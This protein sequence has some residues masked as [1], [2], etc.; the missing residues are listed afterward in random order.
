M[1]LPYFPLHVVAF[2]HLPLPLHIFEERYR[3][4]ARDLVAPES[5]YRGR[6]VVSM[7]TEGQ[8]TGEAATT[9]HRVGTICEVHTA[10]QLPDGRWVVLA[11]GG[12]RAELHEVDRSGPYAT[13]EV[14]PIPERAGAGA[15]EL[16]PEVQAALD[17]Y[18]ET[19]KR[20]AV[21][22]ASEGNQTPG[23]TDVAASLDEV[24]KPIHLPPDPSSASYAVGGVLQIELTRKQQLLELPDA[25]SRLRA[26]LDLLRRESR[27]LANS[28]M[29]PLATTDLEYNPN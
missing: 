25:V 11:V 26:E 22:A 16:L 12:E 3:A 6:F 29:P 10:E 20:F 9:T 19:V 24:L 7:I 23:R 4:M 8:E 13:V 28:A 2:P 5:P 18:L 15:A 21:R 27:L 1:R 14:T 17:A